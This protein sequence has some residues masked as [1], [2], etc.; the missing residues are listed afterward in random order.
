MN[1]VLYSTDCPKCKVLK[2]K[3]AQL[4][5][6]YTE[7]NSVDEMLALGIQEVPVLD[8][9]GSLLSFVDAVNWINEREEE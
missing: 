8:V 1:V 5:I 6:P 4:N 9:G 2:R 7:N 3:L